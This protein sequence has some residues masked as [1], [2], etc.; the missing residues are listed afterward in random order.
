M[1]T[2]VF[3]IKNLNSNYLDNHSYQK[4]ARTNILIFVYRLMSFY[5]NTDMY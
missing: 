5:N 2:G 4:I 1:K 3:L